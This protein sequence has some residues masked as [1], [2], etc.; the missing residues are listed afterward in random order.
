MESQLESKQQSIL[1]NYRRKLLEEQLE[2]DN[3]AQPN[4]RRKRASALAAQT[5]WRNA[6]PESRLVIGL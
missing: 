3:E 2:E 4:R 5:H 1:A 6:E